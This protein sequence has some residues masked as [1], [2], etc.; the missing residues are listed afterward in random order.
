MNRKSSKKWIGLGVATLVLAGGVATAALS[1]GADDDLAILKQFPIA[2][3]VIQRIA[4]ELDLTDAQRGK[5]RAVAASER[6]IM[7]P[8]LRT[9]K[10]DVADLHH[11]TEHDSVDEGAL[12][13]GAR[14]CAHAVT[15]IVV[16][17]QRAKAQVMAILTPAQRG[18]ARAIRADVEA[19][20]TERL[21]DTSG[22]P[23]PVMKMIARR[24]DL[25][26]AQLEKIKTIV[27]GE[28]AA[29]KPGVTGLLNQ[30][31]DMEAL[32]DGGRFDESAVRREAEKAEPAVAT[33]IMDLA[34]TK[35]HVMAVL[36]DEQRAKA[37]QLREGLK[38]RLVK[39]WMQRHGHGADNTFGLGM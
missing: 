12:S 7:T 10:Q 15:D 38:A 19:R 26:G 25:N 36:T 5:I 35:M 27:A 21:Q 24:L 23:R 32:T 31:H 30:W 33:L 16:E 1:Q 28:K 11:I 22:A 29:I 17:S 34:K 20:L 2:Q 9:L 14:T 6:P 39:L 4:T 18:Q 8:L 37:K 3:R 13:T